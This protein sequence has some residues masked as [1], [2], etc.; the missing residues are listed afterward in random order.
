MITGGPGTGKT[1]TVARL[2]VVQVARCRPDGRVGLATPRIA[3][4]APTGRAAARL[5]EAIDGV[6]RADRAAGR[7]L[8]AEIADA[9]P[10]PGPDAPSPARLAT[11]AGRIP[12]STRAIR[13]REDLVVVDEA[14]M[15]D[16][17]L[18]AKL[19]EAV[20]PT[21]RPWC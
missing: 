20:A 10:T 12:P 7:I 18:M 11:G 13:C 19:V 1:T 4:A 21:P 5:G 14:S 17:P 2:L 16:L 6:I 15:V 8:I 9:I 3:L